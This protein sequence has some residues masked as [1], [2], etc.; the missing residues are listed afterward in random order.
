MADGDERRRRRRRGS[1]RDSG[2]RP[3]KATVILV[4]LGVLGLVGG[5]VAVAYYSP[6]MSVRSVDVV[7]TAAVDRNEVL[8][9]ANAPQGVPLLQVDTGAIADRIAVL[10]AVEEVKVERSY[11]STLTIEVTE[12]TPVA[13]L[14][15]QGGIGVMDR[16]G[17]VY[18]TFA[19]RKAVPKT[20][21]RLPILA[22][23]NPG[24]KDPATLAALTVAQELPEWLRSR[25][26]TIE[27]SSPAD[28]TLIMASKRRVIWGDAERTDDKAEALQSALKVNGDTYNVSSP[29]FP[30]VS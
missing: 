23:P 28:I 12:R 1:D 7:G 21:A 10:P 27:A 2:R 15:W 29:E 20:F 30:A 8:R 22:V 4:I 24:S 25:T 17:M 14:D 5:A 3:S 16:L 26:T 6:L 13:T 9:L 18:L 11:P 19:D